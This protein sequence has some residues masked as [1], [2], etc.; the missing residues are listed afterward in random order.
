MIFLGTLMENHG[1]DNLDELKTAMMNPD[2]VKHV[3]VVSKDSAK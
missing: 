2:N 3:D 1:I